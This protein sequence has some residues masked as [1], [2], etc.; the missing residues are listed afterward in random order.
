MGRAFALAVALALLV[1][2]RPAAAG[3]ALLDGLSGAGWTA[4]APPRTFSPDTLYEE[5]DGEAELYLPFGF[6]GLTVSILVSP[7]APGVELRVEAYRHDTPKDAFGI[8]SQYRNTDQETAA[9]GPS[10]AIVS[11]GSLDFFRGD[12]FV[13]MRVAAGMLPR[14]ALLAAGTAAVRA[15]EGPAGAPPGAS[16]VSIPGFVPGTV[17]YQRK[18]M[19]GFEP[20]APGFEARFTEGDASGR[21]IFVEGDAKR[22]AGRLAK[23]LPGFEAA[24]EGE[25]R[26][27]LP[28][29][30]LYLKAAG[31]GAVGV[32]GRMTRAQ[33][34]PRLDAMARRAEA[35]GP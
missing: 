29:G 23:A 3:D 32:V 31:P 4:S 10:E 15:L 17:L 21:L 19:L 14:K 16:V 28:Q 22:T 25:W 8:Y 11:D 20:L 26:A 30:T 12:L 18:A 35:L 9:V 27:S 34:A 33:A 13:R 1:S 24:G 5:I 7:D 6:R 2:G